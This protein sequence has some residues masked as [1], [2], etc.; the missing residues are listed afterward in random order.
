MAT[1][2]ELLASVAF[3]L[4]L[5][6]GLYIV[7]IQGAGP[8][9]AAMYSYIA[10]IDVTAG[11][12]GLGRV[13]CLGDGLRQVIE[14]WEVESYRRE[15]ASAAYRARRVTGEVALVIGTGQGLGMQIAQHL[16]AEGAHVAMA[17]VDDVGV[18]VAAGDVSEEWREGRGTRISTSLAMAS[19][20]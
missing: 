14:D 7:S 5:A 17:D 16:V 10:V 15:M 1:W 2:S 11:V 13:G 18:Q 4:V 8:I 12:V 9:R 6:D 3:A 20:Q 19:I